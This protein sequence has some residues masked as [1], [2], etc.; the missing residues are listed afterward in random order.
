MT[1]DI[2]SLRARLAG[3]DGP[4]FWRSLDAVA[5]S[6]E[7]RAFLDAEYPAAARLAAAP[8]RRGVLKLMAASFA[9]SGLAACGQTDGRK[10]EV[11]Y[12][13]QPERIIPGAALAYASA[14]LTDGFAN[15][16]T[17]TT[18]NG[19]PLKI[20][21]NAEHPWSRGGTDVFAQASVLGLYDPFRLQA[22]RHLGRPSTWQAF[23]AAMTGRF[24]ALKAVEGGRGLHL[25]TGPV[26]SPSLAAQ[27]AAMR[28]DFPAMRW[29]V[30]APTGR[31][32]L[33][34]G[35]R[36][37]YGRPLETRWRFDQAQVVVSLDGDCLDAG[38]GQV[39]QARDW[40]EARRR[41]AAGKRL[42]A[43]HHAGPSPNLTSA[44]A[45]APL[46]IGSDGL[47][48]IVRDLLAQAGG[49]APVTRDGPAAAWRE[50]A[51][52]ALNA[53]RGNGLVLAGAQAGPELLAQVHRLNAAL[54]NTGR[55]VFHTAPVP[56]LDPE[57]LSAL[58]EAMR[59]GAVQV[60]VMLDV[61]P[62]YDAPGDLGFLEAMARVPLKIHAG[63]YPDETA[64][65]C[66]WNLPLAHPLEAWGDARS[67]DGTVTLIQPTIRP[68]YDGRSV[69]EILSILTDAEAKDGGSLLDAH[70]RRPGEDDAA[71]TARR[72]AFLQA[73]FL[74]G[75]AFS[76]EPVGEPV[77]APAALPRPAPSPAGPARRVEVL[78]RPDATVWD[79]SLA[80]LAW[81]QELPKPLT[82]VVWG[83]VIAV[84]P[85]LAEREELQQGDLVTLE[86]GGRRIEGPVWIQPGQA[87]DAVTVGLGYGRT[88]PEQLADGL[89][90]DA[91]PLR[92]SATPW[93]LAEATLATTG[94]KA[95]PV[96]TQNHGTM[97][98]HDLVRVQAVGSTTPVA[99]REPLPS[100]Y[101]PA[102][103]S[104]GGRFARERAWGM[105]IDLDACIGC[106]ACVT[107]CQSENNIPVVGKEE[108]ALGRWLHWLRID[109]YYEGGLDTPKTHFMPVPCMH[110]EQAPCEVGCPVEATVHDREGLNLMVY[111]RC[112]GTRA[113]SSYC[114]YKVRRFNYLD[115]AGDAAPVQQQQR[116]PEVTVRARGVMEKCTYCVQRIAAARIEST[117]GDHAPIPDGAVET[118]C[119]GACPT[120]A[121]SFGDLRDAGSRVAAAAADPRNYALLAELNTRPRTTYLA[122][123]V[124]EAS[125][126]PGGSL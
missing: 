4:A 40:V 55:T 19:R 43:L 97:E 76:P 93:R 113:C 12:V 3:G 68:L 120:R 105:V 61:N 112:V 108:V 78:F 57:P 79:G 73:G 31:E 88:V 9:M 44:K 10:Q 20:E 54:G 41:A 90:Y 49:G 28:R 37:A 102:P 67:L 30:S 71:W 121:I 103:T 83:N 14:S 25:V 1:G 50:T 109:R 101:P 81:L 87:E 111:N 21:G 106:N 119:Q 74:E 56:V 24:A 104:P 92:A 18:R 26:T 124:E 52:A 34:E 7:F 122:R 63:L 59:R 77:P 123:L 46:A 107:A 35:A 11:P 17:V 38:P 116:N 117:R 69:P 13:R 8:D 65:R 66:D 48:Q 45:D 125:V 60:L 29:H 84:S 72:E 23:R 64:F 22:P 95:L 118:A 42:L 6:P 58:V 114:P 75:T 36:L 115:Y 16:I 85:A 110:C 80:N 100:L 70:W 2:A 39:G 96:T 15:G 82:K 62:V 33:Y 126:K 89:G 47:E 91:Y 32:A 27:I 94:R 51:F 99:A 5:D 98:G 53:A 86:A